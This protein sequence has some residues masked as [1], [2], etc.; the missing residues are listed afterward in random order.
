MECVGTA[1]DG[2]FGSVRAEDPQ[3]FRPTCAMHGAL[4]HHMVR[5][6]DFRGD[7]MRI[8]ECKRAGSIIWISDGKE[9][10]WKRFGNVQHRPDD[11]FLP[12]W[13]LQ[14]GRIRHG[15]SCGVLRH[16]CRFLG[17]QQIDGKRPDHTEPDVSF[18]GF[19]ARGSMVFV[20]RTLERSL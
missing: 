5:P 17:V 16:D 20:R 15:T 18:S 7:T 3:R 13:M 4:G 11:G 12:G 2:F 19:A 14:H 6:A 1:K 10:T 8:T 9:C